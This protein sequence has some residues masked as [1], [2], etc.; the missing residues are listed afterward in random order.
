MSGVVLA[1][2][3]SSRFGSEDKLRAEVDGI[4]LLHHPIRRLAEVTGDVVVVLAPG[5]PEPALPAGAPVRIARDARDD[6]G[7]LEG[8]LAGLAI[9]DRELA[10]VAGGDMPGLSQ[11][12]LRAM[13][14]VAVEAPADAVALQDGDR[15]RPLPA[16]VRVAP[17]RTAAERLLRDGE[18]SLRAWLRA[19]GPIVVDEPAW[20]A[21]DPEH[22]TL[23][24]IDEASDLDE[25]SD[26]DLT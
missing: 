12:V 26:R 23:R 19:M 4:P 7:P 2:G 3:R 8:A 10:V 15:F 20:V 24:D 21:L 5:G 18:R 9:V 25:A 6:E 1:G 16:V 17:A 22:V 13:V 14:R 11:A